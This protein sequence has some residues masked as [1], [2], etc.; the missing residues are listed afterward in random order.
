MFYIAV[1]CVQCVCCIQLCVVCS[2]VLC[3]CV[4]FSCCVQL[5]AGGGVEPLMSLVNSNDA[6]VRRSASWAV[7]VAS[8]DE[9]TATEIARFK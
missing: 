3:V 5:C 8:T 7:A 4:Q 1:Y 2:H 9:D 6:D